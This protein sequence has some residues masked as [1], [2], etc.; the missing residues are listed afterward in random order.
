MT[1]RIRRLTFQRAVTR[2]IWESLSAL[3]RASVEMVWQRPKSKQTGTNPGLRVGKPFARAMASAN[4]RR[5][6]NRP[7]TLMYSSRA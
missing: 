4:G 3:E 6:V 1:T 7:H 2:E 5:N